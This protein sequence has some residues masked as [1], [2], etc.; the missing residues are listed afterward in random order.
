MTFNQS[1]APTAPHWKVRTTAKKRNSNPRHKNWD[2]VRPWQM[3]AKFEF[4]E[5]NFQWGL[6]AWMKLPLSL[7]RC[8][9]RN[10]NREMCPQFFGKTALYWRK[11]ARFEWPSSWGHFRAKN[12]PISNEMGAVLTEGTPRCKKWSPSGKRDR[13]DELIEQGLANKERRSYLC[14]VGQTLQLNQD[15]HGEHLGCLYWSKRNRTSLY[16]YTRCGKVRMYVQAAS[17]Y[18]PFWTNTSS[19]NVNSSRL[20][21]DHG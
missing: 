15:Q 13:M 21:K 7:A 17:S 10:L 18:V 8:T 9:P 20:P 1:T 5:P 19:D 6:W 2:S 16:M 14:R 3:F 11:C 4:A 12:G